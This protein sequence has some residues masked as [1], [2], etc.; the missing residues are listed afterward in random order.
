ML[1]MNENRTAVGSNDHATHHHTTSTDW[2]QHDPPSRNMCSTHEATHPLVS[3]MFCTRDRAWHEDHERHSS[4]TAYTPP[5]CI[6]WSSTLPVFS[7]VDSPIRFGTA[8][9]RA[10]I[11]QI[12]L[13][14]M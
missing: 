4:P 1:H 7:R 5:V 9:I 13:L 3:T 8:C 10:T 6:P 12:S 2:C 11:H 14:D